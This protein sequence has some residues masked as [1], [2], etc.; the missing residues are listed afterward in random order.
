M[1]GQVETIGG[2]GRGVI[3]AG[4][5]QHGAKTGDRLSVGEMSARSESSD[6]HRNRPII[7]D[8]ASAARLDCSAGK[9]VRCPEDL[10]A[11]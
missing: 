10:K 3:H 5:S 1:I 8:F 4:Y 2:H 7:L 6:C 11:D 9:A